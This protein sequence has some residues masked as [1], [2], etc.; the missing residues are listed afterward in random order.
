MQQLTIVGTNS[1]L[2]I[3]PKK[4]KVGV[5]TSPFPRIF[6]FRLS[7]PLILQRKPPR[8]L[9]LLPV[10][11]FWVCMSSHRKSRELQKLAKIKTAMANVQA[12]FQRDK[13]TCVY[14]CTAEWSFS[15]APRFTSSFSFFFF[16]L[17]VEQRSTMKNIIHKG[18]SGTVPF[19]FF[20]H[21]TASHSSFFFSLFLFPSF[22][23]FFL[24]FFLIAN[25]RTLHSSK[26]KKWKKNKTTKVKATSKHTHTHTHEKRKKIKCTFFSESKR[27]RS[28][29]EGEK[30]AHN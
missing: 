11:L 1:T 23:S 13:K 2:T 15:E 9:L 6:L 29:R 5:K 18:L 19:F 14:V 28:S 21:H 3:T 17:L 7:L 12:N 22:A 26:K 27:K 10:L 20:L 24:F 8:A 16:F 30:K 25:A 4:K